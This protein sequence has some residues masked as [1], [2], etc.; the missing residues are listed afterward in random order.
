LAAQVDS[1]YQL[2]PK[3]KSTLLKRKKK[4]KER[5]VKQKRKKWT[6]G[7]REKTAEHMV[8]IVTLNGKEIKIIPLG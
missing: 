3:I 5:E 8:R 4:N 1:N 2:P 6:S 7:R